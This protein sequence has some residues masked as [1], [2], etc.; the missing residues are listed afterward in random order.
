[1]QHI[2]YIDNDVK[3]LVAGQ[4]TFPSF[5]VTHSLHHEK[6]IHLC[7]NFGRTPLLGFEHGNFTFKTTCL[8]R[9][10]NMVLAENTVRY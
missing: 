1:M 6:H 2:Q 3:M 4:N 5:R 10:F 7:P 9:R 8:T